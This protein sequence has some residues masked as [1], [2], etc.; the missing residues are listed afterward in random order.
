MGP[1]GS[2]AQTATP[3]YRVLL[4]W[5][6]LDR[7]ARSPQCLQ[8]AQPLSRSDSLDLVRNHTTVTKARSSIAGLVT[9]PAFAFSSSE[10]DLCERFIVI[11]KVTEH[12]LPISPFAPASTN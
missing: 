10:R 2:D 9:C 11:M 1:K 7:F 5:E 8:K 4:S 12:T 6:C 3:K